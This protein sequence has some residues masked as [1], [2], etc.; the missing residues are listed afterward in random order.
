MGRS[1][2]STADRLDA[3]VAA[4]RMLALPSLV[5]FSS[6]GI[7][8]RASAPIFSRDAIAALRSEFLSSF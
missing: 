4:A 3:E 5:A 6:I 1:T 8:A 7:A 2:M